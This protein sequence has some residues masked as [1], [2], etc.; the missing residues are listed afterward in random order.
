[1]LPNGTIMKGRITTWVAERG[2]GF[3][4]PDDGSR[5]IFAHRR[6][7]PSAF[8]PEV[9]QTVE[10]EIETV[11]GRVW[12]RSVRPIDSDIPLPHTLFRSTGA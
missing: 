8:R 6:A 9:G 5:D 11:N 10:I 4:R 1:M 2:F 7:F 3:V 12:A